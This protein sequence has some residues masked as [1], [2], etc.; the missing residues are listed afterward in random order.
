MLGGELGQDDLGRFL[1]VTQGGNELYVTEDWNY[2]LY[3][4]LTKTN[5]LI[6]RD[7]VAEWLEAV[8]VERRL[9]IEV[10]LLAATGPLISPSGEEA[11][12]PVG[13]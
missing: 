8:P 6:R 5:R 11:P 7:D 1:C 3:D 12:V 9:A 2:V 13:S 4:P 10:T